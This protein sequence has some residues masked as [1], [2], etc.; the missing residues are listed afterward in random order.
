MKLLTTALIAT[1]AALAVYAARRRI[2]FALRTGAIVYVI[3]LFAR[4]LFSA[5]SLSDRWED[6]LW[7]IVGMALVW[8]VAWFGSNLYLQRRERRGR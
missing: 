6:V 8:A 5:F 1:L 2:L 7:P 4:L 3:V